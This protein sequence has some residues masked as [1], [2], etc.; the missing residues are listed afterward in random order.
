MELRHVWYFCATLEAGSFVAA[1]SKLR[2]AQPALSRQIQD[3]ERELGVKLFD[4]ERTGVRPTAA[5][6][7]FAGE[8]RR[9]TGQLA[10]AMS[11][12]RRAHAGQLGTCRIGV[13][14]IP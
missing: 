4:R 6:I 14:H 7:I 8:A 10:R 3:L 9:L 13:G 2:V 1:A 5:G 12:V 11:A